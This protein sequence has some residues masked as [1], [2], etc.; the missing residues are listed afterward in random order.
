MFQQYF[1]AQILFIVFIV[2]VSA[3]TIQLIYFWFFYR[4]LAFGHDKGISVQK[5]PVSIVICARNEYQNLLT[6]LPGILEQ[7]YPEFEVVVVNDA[8]D[9]ESIYLLRDFA[10]KYSNLKI[11]D[12]T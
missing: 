7:D 3:A 1:N 8:S 6:Y 12:L 5:L 11:V 2:F 9:D 10:K 4:R